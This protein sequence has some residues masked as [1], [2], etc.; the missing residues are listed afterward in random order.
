MSGGTFDY[1]QYRIRDIYESIQNILDK[2]GKEKL[3]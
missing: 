3:K 1:S 2:Q